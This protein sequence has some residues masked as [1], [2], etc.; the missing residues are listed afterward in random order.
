M[1]DMLVSNENLTHIHPI[2]AG[3]FQLTKDGVPASPVYHEIFP[4]VINHKAGIVALRYQSVSCPE[5]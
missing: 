3:P 4:A 5:H 2:K 1:V